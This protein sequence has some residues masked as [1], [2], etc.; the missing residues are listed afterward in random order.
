MTAYTTD[1]EIIMDFLKLSSICADES[2]QLNKRMTA[3]LLE[4]HLH[5]LLSPKNVP[6][7]VINSIRK[8]YLIDKY[9]LLLEIGKKLN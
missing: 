9:T 4:R 7:Y 3:L 6:M 1:I 5:S 2:I 8:I